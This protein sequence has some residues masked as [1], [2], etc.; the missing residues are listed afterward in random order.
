MGELT[1]NLGTYGWFPDVLPSEGADPMSSDDERADLR[2][3]SRQGPDNSS[4][5]TDSAG[6]AELQTDRVRRTFGRRDLPG[7]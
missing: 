5:S 2:P 3:E 1:V 6:G 7:I 4:S